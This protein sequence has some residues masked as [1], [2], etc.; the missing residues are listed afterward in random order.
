MHTI[1]SRLISYKSVVFLQVDYTITY[2]FYHH[3]VMGI[4]GY[5]MK[6]FSSKIS[7]ILSL[8]R[9]C[10][11]L[12]LILT[13]SLFVFIVGI[14]T[15]LLKIHIDSQSQLNPSILGNWN[16]YEIHWLLYLSHKY[17]HNLVY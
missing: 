9:L 11:S 3:K 15:F 2:L 14:I 12:S 7:L 1:Y 13:I 5:F 8:I 16:K 17:H 6:S 10:K 4:F